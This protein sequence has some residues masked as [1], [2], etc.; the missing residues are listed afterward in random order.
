MEYMENTA[1]NFALQLGS[2][3]TL[4]I[5]IGSLI[6]LLF[7][8]ITV[9]YP[10]QAQMPWE[11]ESATSSIRFTIA[12]LIVFFPSYVVLTRFVNT[13]RRT[14]QGT[15]L[16]LTKWLIYLSLLVGGG[17]LLGDLVAVLNGFLE[18]ELTIRFILKALAV[19]LVTGS[20]FTYYTLDV[21]G[22]WKDNERHSLYYAGIIGAVV[23]VSL[24]TGFMNT[25]TPSQVRN[26]NLDSKQLFDLQEIQSRIES[27]S[28]LHGGL[29]TTMNEAYDSL[30]VPDAPDDRSTYTYQ[31]V[32]ANSFKLCAE[33]ANENSTSN[34]MYYSEKGMYTEPLTI[35]NPNDWNHGAGIWCFT[36]VLNSEE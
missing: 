23:L 21:R 9:Q 19:L 25:E 29:P 32:E 30:T 28:I 5:S 17:V 22:Y 2:L 31:V 35:K 16:T 15:Y 7:G 6:G 3:V 13:I 14:E 27:Y 12:M 24:I 33:F 10:D 34:D 4:Y 11:Y 20:A 1:K 26:K 36:R 18:G 8:I